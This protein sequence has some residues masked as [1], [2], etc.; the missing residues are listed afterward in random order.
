MTSG[1]LPTSSSVQNLKTIVSCRKKNL[2]SNNDIDFE[3]VKI[4]LH[5]LCFLSF[6][7]FIDIRERRKERERETFVV[8][9]FKH[10][11]ADFCMCP[12][13]KESNPQPWHTGMML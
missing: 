9:L 1:L 4:Y 2:N 5:N 6:Y 3:I 13:P 11:L 10:S 8:P 7:L 12:N